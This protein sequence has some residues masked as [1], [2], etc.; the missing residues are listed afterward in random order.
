MLL[1]MVNLSFL[2]VFRYLLTKFKNVSECFEPMKC[3][4][5]RGTLGLKLENL[6]SLEPQSKMYLVIVYLFSLH[7][8][9]TV[10][11]I[12][13]VPLFITGFANNCFLQTSLALYFVI[14]LVGVLLFS[15]KIKFA[16]VKL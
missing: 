6:R 11:N 8:S 10:N 16:K 14:L 3:L 13:S 5:I 9:L 12:L 15:I 4:R 2:G 1:N 7:I